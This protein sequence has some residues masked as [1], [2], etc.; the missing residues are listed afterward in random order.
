MIIVLANGLE[1]N[2]GVGFAIVSVAKFFTIAEA[3]F[4]EPGDLRSWAPA[5]W[6]DKT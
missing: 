6:R 5:H 1:I 4:A 2:R 3:V